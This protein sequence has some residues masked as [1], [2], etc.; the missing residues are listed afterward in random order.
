MFH[1]L[2]QCIYNSQ[3]CGDFKRH[4]K[5]TATTVGFCMTFNPGTIY[6]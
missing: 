5:R 2:L 4:F 3:W 6:C 1:L